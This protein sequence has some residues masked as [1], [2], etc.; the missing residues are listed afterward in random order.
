[1]EIIMCCLGCIACFWC[2]V[3]AAGGVRLPRRHKTECRV[4]PKTEE[5]ALSRDIAAML[6]Y[7]I[8]RRERED[9]A[10]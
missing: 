5:D 3:W 6:A 1:M 10:N 2:G 8:P 9:E 4:T 7:T